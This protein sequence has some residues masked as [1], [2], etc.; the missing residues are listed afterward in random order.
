MV[1]VSLLL[2]LYA[3]ARTGRVPAPDVLSLLLGPVCGPFAEPL[4]TTRFSSAWMFGEAGMLA[5]LF[6]LHPL[7]PNRLTAII[8]SLALVIWFYVGCCHIYTRY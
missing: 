8:S 7:R 4:V 2:G 6:T 5:G 3:I 1:V